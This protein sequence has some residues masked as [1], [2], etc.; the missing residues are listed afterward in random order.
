[1][2]QNKK[3]QGTGLVDC[4]RKGD[5]VDWTQEGQ[6]YSCALFNPSFT[7]NDKYQTVNSTNGHLLK[8]KGGDNE[9]EDVKFPL[10][11]YRDGYTNAIRITMSAYPHI[12]PLDAKG[13]NGRCWSSVDKFK[14][15]TDVNGKASDV[16]SIALKAYVGFYPPGHKLSE[17]DFVD[18]ALGLEPGL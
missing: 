10:H 1:M 5:F 12:D 8:A 15:S 7:Y 6:G 18:I 11:A 2:A 17:V 9:L 14:T 16:Q 3:N 4:G 13:N